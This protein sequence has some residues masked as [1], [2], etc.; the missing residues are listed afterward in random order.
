MLRN[1]WS[2]ELCNVVDRQLNGGSM[3]KLSRHL[4]HD[5]QTKSIQRDRPAKLLNKDK[6]IAKH[7]E[8]AMKRKLLDKDIHSSRT[9]THGRETAREAR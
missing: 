6:E 3:W 9:V 2:N 5:T 1:Q 8:D 4:L 7:N